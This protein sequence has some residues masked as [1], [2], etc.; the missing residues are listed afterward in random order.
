[1]NKNIIQDLTLGQK[2]DILLN[3]NFLSD[4]IA[5]DFK[6]HSLADLDNFSIQD[7]NTSLLFTVAN[8]WNLELV[9]SV[10]DR[11]AKDIHSRKTSIIFTPFFNAKIKNGKNGKIENLAEEIHFTRE[12]LNHYVTSFH[13]QNLYVMGRYYEE[14]IS[15]E[16]NKTLMYETLEMI[17]SCQLDGV[18]IYNN[19]SCATILKNEFN[20]E[21]LILLKTTNQLNQPVYSF[22]NDITNKYNTKD[23]LEKAINRFKEYKSKLEE[24]LIDNKTFINALNQQMI[25][26]EKEL[27]NE[28]IKILNFLSHL[29][30]KTRL[31]NLDIS[32]LDIKNEELFLNASKESMVL[33]KNE[34]NFLPISAKPGVVLIG[35]FDVLFEKSQETEMRKLISRYIPNCLGYY[36]VFDSLSGDNYQLVENLLKE[37]N[38]ASVVIIKIESKNYNIK[39]SSS[40]IYFLSKLREAGKDVI[41]ALSPSIQCIDKWEQYCSALILGRILDYSSMKAFLSIIV[42]D[43]VPSGKLSHAIYQHNGT[44]LSILYPFGFGLSYTAYRYSNLLIDKNKVSFKITNTGKEIG[45]ETPQLY[46][47]QNNLTDE[48]KLIGFKKVFLAAGETNKIEIEFGNWIKSGKNY[49]FEV[50]SSKKHVELT[51]AGYNDNTQTDLKT[52]DLSKLTRTAKPHTLKSFNWKLFITLLLAI[53][54]NFSSFK[55][56]QTVTQNDYFV[57]ILIFTVMI[58]TLLFKLIR[59]ILK[60]KVKKPAA[61]SLLH[62]MEDM[63]NLEASNEEV[64]LTDGASAKDTDEQS[65]EITPLGND[66]DEYGNVTRI[67][68]PRKVISVEPIYNTELQMEHY[69]DNLC[70]YMV[71]NGLKIEKRIARE[72]LSCTAAS[73]MIIVKSERTDIAKRFLEI[74]NDFIGAK[75]FVETASTVWNSFGDLFQGESQLKNC[76]VSAN[77]KK[78]LIHIMTLN[79]VDLSTMEKYFASIIDFAT[80]PLMPCYIK[81]MASFGVS[82]L[83]KNIWFMLIPTNFDNN[84]IPNELIQCS[85]I[86]DLDAKIV[87]PKDTVKQ[88][89]LKLSHNYFMDSLRDSADTYFVNEDLW[90]KVDQIEYFVN[91]QTPFNI[92]NRVFRQLERYTTMYIMSGGEEYEAI[93]SILAAKLLIMIAKLSLRKTDDESEGLYDLCEKLFGLDNLTRSKVLLKQIEKINIL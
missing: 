89:E 93:D 41:V 10:A 88:N 37:I 86:I 58:D 12:L 75:S 33:L 7:D 76:I 91:K 50:S 17:K 83:P 1:M 42:G 66:V 68:K 11:I 90:K 60:T 49:T 55:L 71:D 15:D 81:E 22:F 84:T 5:N 3:K 40:Q 21:G 59:D 29:Y 69:C 82:E 25:I 45:Y 34:N 39:L 18:I 19:T 31:E 38:D 36:K 16:S 2:L 20:Y 61:D 77:K 70:Q 64:Y 54:I 62:L 87:L 30:D 80:N 73:H 92:D 46:V 72:I 6:L 24:K 53:L 8:S 48:K 35:D 27:N 47:Y 14:G 13:R 85:V 32:M 67:L 9:Q 56:L 57:A 23:E 52:A 28:I 78:D 65:P 79:H 44:S 51:L 26:D 63:E 4:I 74:Y 43:E